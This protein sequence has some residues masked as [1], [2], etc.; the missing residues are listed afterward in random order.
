MSED[1]FEQSKSLLLNHIQT[2]LEEIEQELAMTHQEKY[3][4]LEDGCE[5]ASDEDELRVA[6]EQWHI[7]HA[8]DIGFEHGIDDLWNHAMGAEIMDDDNFDTDDGVTVFDDDE[9][10]DEDEDIE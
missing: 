7:E 1:S 8:E 9:D 3:V 2:L 10:E 6:F 4:L 5:N